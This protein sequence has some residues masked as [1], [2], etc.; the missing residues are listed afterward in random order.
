MTKKLYFIVSMNLSITISKKKID[1]VEALWFTPS[2]KSSPY[3]VLRQENSIHARINKGDFLLSPDRYRKHQE[4]LSR[5][6]WDI[7]W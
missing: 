7:L 6:I 5:N 3:F 2:H 1:G 4:K